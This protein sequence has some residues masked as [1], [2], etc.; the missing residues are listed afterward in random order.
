MSPAKASAPDALRSLRGLRSAALVRAASVFSS[1]IFTR[2]RRA[3]GPTVFVSMRRYSPSLYGQ[4]SSMTAFGSAEPPIATFRMPIRA[5]NG[6]RF[7]PS[8][9]FTACMHSMCTPLAW[10]RST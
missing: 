1:A 7:E 4:T 8:A 9:P 3:I 2:A 6:R 10:S 5:K